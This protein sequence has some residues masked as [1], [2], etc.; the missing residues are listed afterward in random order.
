MEYELLEALKRTSE[1]SNTTR[2][3]KKNTAKTN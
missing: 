2:E 1:D 3:L